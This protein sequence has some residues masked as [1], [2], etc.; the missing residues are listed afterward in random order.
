MKA[1]L[2][3]IT[4]FIAM[5]MVCFVLTYPRY[6]REIDAAKTNLLAGSEI[7]RAENGDIEYAVK[8]EGAPVLLLH[9][10]GGGYDQGLWTR[11]LALGDGYRFISVSRFGY[12]RSPIPKDASIKT[13][14]ALYNAL[15]DSLKIKKVI[16]IGFS[17][18]GPSGTQFCNDCPD[19]CSAL[20]LL[21]A[22]S[23]TG[24]P[25]DKPP[26]YIGIIHLIQQSDYAYWLMAK[27]M[28]RMMLSLFG[29]PSD[30]YQKF[31]P[32]QKAMAQEMLDIMHPMKHRYK[33]TVN[34]G[35]MIQRAVATSEK[36]SAP[37]LIIHA[38]DD[39][40]VNYHH[41]ENAHSKIKQSKLILLDTGG[42]VMLSQINRVR[43]YVRQFLKDV[44]SN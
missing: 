34:D 19:K 29:I 43:E 30:V 23:E 40:L 12:L 42:H 13:Q 25:G 3:I 44:D 17:A 7:L 32:E 6:R 26:F 39:A 5:L 2:I 41:A 20:I 27:F 36:I 33:G 18:G 16:V 31:A 4:I 21:S 15:L 9:G 10:A 1:F 14:A 24:A 37:T 22:V 8:G 11:N 38:K 28:Q 35:E